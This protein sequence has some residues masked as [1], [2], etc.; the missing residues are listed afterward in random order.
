MIIQ[1]IHAAL[2][3]KLLSD[4][5]TVC[6]KYGGSIVSF[7]RS[8]QR[9]LSKGGS[10]TSWHLD[11]LAGDIAVDD[12]KDKWINIK[13]IEINLDRIGYRT[14]ETAFEGIHVQ[15]DWP[16]INC[17]PEGQIQSREEI[18]QK[19]WATIKEDL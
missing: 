5:M 13:Q 7:G 18:H 19:I 12:G 17:A 10:A 4:V 3:D 2:R 11:W 1:E 16:I 14:T 6:D 8:I 9:N 15:Y